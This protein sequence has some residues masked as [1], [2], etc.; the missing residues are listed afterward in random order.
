MSS[1]SNIAHTSFIEGCINK[2][3]TMQDIYEAL[4]LYSETADPRKEPVFAKDE[5]NDLHKKIKEVAESFKVSYHNDR[6]ELL[7]ELVKDGA[8]AD[9]VQKLVLLYGQS[10]WGRKESQPTR[11]GVQ[12]GA[13]TDDLN[14]EKKADREL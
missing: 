12:Q 11:Y 8:F 14:W 7:A 9:D 3:R 13:V 10:L 2:K 5:A 6:E 4:G 1:Q